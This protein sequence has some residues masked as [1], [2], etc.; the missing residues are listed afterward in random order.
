MR[1]ILA[2]L[3]VASLALPA[4]AACPAADK[5]VDEYGIGF[6]GFEKAIPKVVQP[7]VGGTRADALVVIRLPNRKGNVPD[8]FRHAALVDKEKQQA[9][10]RRRGGF[11]PVDEWYGPV[12]VDGRQLA[13][14]AVEAWR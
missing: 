5:L 11:V 3:I 4:M 9:W 8:G 10:I 2:F 13:G 6:G 14:C 7:V 12:R 1:Q